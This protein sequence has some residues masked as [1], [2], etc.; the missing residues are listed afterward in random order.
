MTRLTTPHRLR[1][2]LGTLFLALAVPSAVLVWYTE[3]QVRLEAWQQQRVAAETLAQALERR[4]ERLIVREEARAQSDYRFL[5]ITGDPGRGVLAQRSPLAQWPGPETAPGLLGHFEVGP[6]GDFATPLVPEQGG[7]TALGMAPAEWRARLARRGELIEVLTRNRL[8]LRTPALTTGSAAA[9]VRDDTSGA[10]GVAAQAAFDRLNRAV[11]PAPPPHAMRSDAETFAAADAVS[12]ARERAAPVQAPPAA[13]S[14]RAAAT[15]A[16]PHAKSADVPGGDRGQAALASSP[17][18]ALPPAPRIDLFEGVVAPFEF[19]R[20]DSGH[21]VLFRRVWREGGRSIQ[22]LL[23]DAAVFL[24]TELLAPFRD[25]ALA[26]MTT[27]TVDWRGTE[28]ARAAGTGPLHEALYRKQLSAPFGELELVFALNRLQPGPGATLARWTGLT[29]FALLVLG[30]VGLYRLGQGQLALARQQ[31]DFVAAVSHELKTPL[32]SIRMYGELLREAW[33]PEEKRRTYYAYIHDESERLSRLIGNVLQLA[34]LER[35]ALALTLEPVTVEVLYELLRTRLAVP[36][37][38]AGFVARF[39]FDRGLVGS[40]VA[41][42][43]DALVQILVNLVDNAL[44][45][46]AHAACRVVAIAVRGAGADGVVF[47]VRDHGP[48]VARAQRRRIFELFY[49]AADGSSRDTVGT[50]IGLALV[51]ELVAA[52]RGKVDVIEARPG[53]EFRVWLPR[54]A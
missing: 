35:Q 50:G 52:M 29:L 48:G 45:F 53:A 36:I 31:H 2:L 12:S 49:R 25:S 37:E 18:S 22:G 47:S 21:F 27:L 44:K 10:A 15:A 6:D 23:L 24:D 26:D 13:P 11:S 16:A 7:A 3:K 54:A 34:R 46:S 32:T 41:V 17:A 20:L 4:L 14:A 5:T 33:V 39:E 30:F 1:W 9:A 42:D 51:R 43:R 28:L 19:S 8:L 40:Q 38:R